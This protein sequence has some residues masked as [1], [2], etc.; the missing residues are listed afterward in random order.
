M[1][2]AVTHCVSSGRRRFGCGREE[3]FEEVVLGANI[4][5]GR[6]GRDVGGGFQH[7]ESY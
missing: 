5:I 2:G 6:N 3:Q 7:L 1:E 4:G